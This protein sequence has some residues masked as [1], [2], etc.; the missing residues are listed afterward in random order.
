MEKFGDAYEAD[1]LTYKMGIDRRFTTAIAERFRGRHVLETCTGAGFT[2][3]SLA[4]SA[5]SVVTMEIDPGHQK[6]AKYNVRKA[7]LT[8]GVTFLLGDV[9]DEG[10]LRRLPAVDAAFLD[11]DWADTG[12]NHVYRFI[13]S[14]TRPPADVLL[15]KIFNI[16]PNVA[17]ILPPFVDV[18]EFN[19]LCS[20]ERQKLYMGDSLELF[21]LYF[22][23]LVASIGETE[24]WVRKNS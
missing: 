7:G 16:T 18:H 1:A 20:H 10:L 3:I 9:M 4:R 14:N 19:G 6:Q 17:L 24:L 2:T 13:D 11:P 5:S 12:P 21:C 8:S 23:D 15:K 22:G